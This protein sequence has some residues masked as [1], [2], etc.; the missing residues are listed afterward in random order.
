MAQLA[1]ERIALPQ[2]SIDGRT[3]GDGHHRNGG[4][5]VATVAIDRIRV[6]V[7]RGTAYALESAKHLT[8]FWHV[9]FRTCPLPAAVFT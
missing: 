3:I 9:R 1:T 4:D 2:A 8:R 7:D 6:R 5:S